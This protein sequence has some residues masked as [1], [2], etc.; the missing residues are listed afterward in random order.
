VLQQRAAGE[1]AP[2]EPPH[3]CLLMHVGS[4]QARTRL[5]E[6]QRVHRAAHWGRFDPAQDASTVPQVKCWVL[7]G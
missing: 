5:Q 4:V 6:R 2:H 1:A 3:V 7:G